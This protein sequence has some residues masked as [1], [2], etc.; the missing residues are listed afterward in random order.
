[1]NIVDV[2]YRSVHYFAIG[3]TGT[4]L[5]VDCGWPGT[6]PLLLANLKRFDIALSAFK[7]LLVTHFHPDHAGLAQEL[8]HA[9]LQLLVFDGQDAFIPRLKQWMKPEMHYQDITLHDNVAMSLAGSR[10]FLKTIGIDGQV[11]ATP[12]HS[13]DSVSLILD[14]GDAFIGDLMAPFAATEEN[15]ATVTASWDAIRAAGG[16]TIHHAHAPMRRI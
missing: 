1:M 11:I 4:P 2:G 13:D 10:A 3:S 6:L 7:Y 5:L 15:A 12:G 14:C 9:G 8:K 16:R